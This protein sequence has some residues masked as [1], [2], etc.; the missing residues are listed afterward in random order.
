MYKVIKY[1]LDLQ[2]GN[3]PYHVGDVFPR[4]GV[5]VKEERLEELAGSENRQKVPLIAK[6][7]ETADADEPKEPVK[8]KRAKKNAEK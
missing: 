3:H 2:D 1:F 5:E 8:G 4:S 6:V 7:D